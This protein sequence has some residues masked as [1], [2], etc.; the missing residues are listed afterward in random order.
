MQLILFGFMSRESRLIASVVSTSVDNLD[1]DDD[2]EGEVGEDA[3]LND[4]LEQLS[5]TSGFCLTSF[6]L[7][8]G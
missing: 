1:D 6:A 2:G 8:I 3:G 5:S 4:L 7:L